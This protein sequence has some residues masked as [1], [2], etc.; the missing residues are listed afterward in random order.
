MTHSKDKLRQEMIRERKQI[1][2]EKRVAANQAIAHSVITFPSF[3]EA[4]RVC[5]YLSRP[6]EVESWVLLEELLKTK[7]MVIVPKVVGDSL[8]LHTIAS[9]NDLSLQSFGIWEPTENARE[10][11][12]D[13]VDLFIVPG[14]VFDR[15]G[16]RIGWGRGYYDKL[17][18]GSIVPKIGLAYDTQVVAEVP[19]TSYDVPMTAVI[20]EKEI[21]V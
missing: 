11:S 7:E 16:Y 20:T 14:V 12:R 17:L 13:L 3:M 19:H 21:I 15:H 4:F 9:K 2:A 5:L 18:S 10:V 6:E 1:P 8:T